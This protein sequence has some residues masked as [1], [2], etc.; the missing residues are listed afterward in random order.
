MSLPIPV[1]GVDAGPDYA[2]NIDNCLS[3]LDSHDHSNG[4]GIQITPA[5]LNLNADLTF[6]KNNAVTL[7][8]VRFSPQSSSFSSAADVGCL[9]ELGVDLYYIDGNGNSIRLTQSGSIVGTSGSIGN[10]VAPASVTF[11]SGTSTYV[12]QSNVNVPGNLDGAAITLRNLTASSNG[13]TIQPVSS[14]ASNY[15]ITLP[16]PPSV[17]SIMAMDSS[18]AIT[19]PY[20]VDNSTITIASNVIKVAPAGITSTELAANS[21]TSSQIAAGAVGTSELAANAV[22]AANMYGNVQAF[23]ASGTGTFTTQANSTTSTVYEITMVGG[24]GGYGGG[25]GGGAAAYLLS[26]V[27]G[28]AA[29]QTISFTIGSPGANSGTTGGDGTNTIV[30]WPTGTLVVGGGFGGTPIAAGAGGNYFTG[31]GAVFFSPGGFGSAGGGGG[32]FGSGPAFGG[33]ATFG[34]NAGPGAVIIKRLTAY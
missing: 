12:F 4:K 28:A 2:L 19:A 25:G 13:V 10:L 24:G 17:I 27:S 18:G 32:F 5:G 11:I 29:N 21:V 14:L 15:T 6:N 16:Q 22:T 20:T 8:S 3:I 1:V 9:Y 23:A 30:Y 26:Y 34:T 33:G 31:V 7:R